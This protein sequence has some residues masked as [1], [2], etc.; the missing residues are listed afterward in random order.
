METTKKE[1]QDEDHL[2][3]HNEKQEQ[4][5]EQAT[6]TEETNKIDCVL[7]Q[8]EA[9]GVIKVQELL[10]TT[11]NVLPIGDTVFGNNLVKIMADGCQQFMNKTGRTGITYSELRQMYG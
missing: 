11:K 4:E 3:C 6:L 7:S 5:Q 9:E 8:L 2:Y 10:K 1:E